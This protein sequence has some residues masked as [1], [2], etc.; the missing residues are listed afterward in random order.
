MTL[1]RIGSN[2]SDCVVKCMVLLEGLE[3]SIEMDV[4][5]YDMALLGLREIQ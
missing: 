3:V 4:I 2:S 1:K 5:H